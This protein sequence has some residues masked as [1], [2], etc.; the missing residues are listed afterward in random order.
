VAFAQ[1][2]LGVRYANGQGVERDPVQAY[3]WF[4]LAA[5]GLLGKEADTARQARDSIKSTLTPEQVARG[6]EMVKTWRPKPES[7]GAASATPRR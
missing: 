1:F 4:S 2:N 5:Q 7:P 3:L 6:D